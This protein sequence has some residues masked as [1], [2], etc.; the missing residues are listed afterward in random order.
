METFFFIASVSEKL[1]WQWHRLN[2]VK[3]NAILFPFSHFYLNFSLY[4][5]RWHF[6]CVTIQLSE[7]RTWFDAFIAINRF[8]HL[9]LFGLIDSSTGHILTRFLWSWF[10]FLLA[11]YKIIQCFIFFLFYSNGT[12]KIE[13]AN[14]SLGME[15]PV[16]IKHLI[17]ELISW[18]HSVYQRLVNITHNNRTNELTLIDLKWWVIVSGFTNQNNY[19]FFSPLEEMPCLHNLAFVFA[20]ITINHCTWFYFLLNLFIK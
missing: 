16:Q 8:V 19:N 1:M 5:F 4:L 10:F 7:K 20:F 6:E 9:Y 15:F 3:V 14:W 11:F 13:T 18:K 17:L 2:D 12:F